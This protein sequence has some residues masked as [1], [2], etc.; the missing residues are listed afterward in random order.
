MGNLTRTSAAL[1]VC[2]VLPVFMIDVAAGPGPVRGSNPGICDCKLDYL[3]QS[4]TTKKCSIAT[5]TCPAPAN[6]DCVTWSAM[7]LN[8]PR[9]GRCNNLFNCENEKLPCITPL[10][11]FTFTYSTLC[12]VTCCCSSD[13][14]LVQSDRGGLGNLA[15]G[16]PSVPVDVG[17]IDAACDSSPAW[18]VAVTCNEAEGPGTMLYELDRAY[19]CNDCSDN[20]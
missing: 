10:I 18:W 5:A 13:T 16:G 9:D 3:G 20:D 1:A 15:R 12:A 11:R 8:D 6:Q 17:G 2:V 4:G 7:S 19:T 14:S